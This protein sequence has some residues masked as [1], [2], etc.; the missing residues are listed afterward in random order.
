MPPRGKKAT[1][2]KAAAAKRAGVAAATPTES[3]SIQVLGLSGSWQDQELKEKLHAVAGKESTEYRV[4]DSR[5]EV[6]VTVRHL[7]EVL[8]RFKSLRTPFDM[9]QWRKRV[10]IVRFV[11]CFVTNAS[12]ACY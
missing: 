3:T 4:N 7:I 11:T 1:S 6:I 9:I 2:A 8:C 10:P 5:S 12:L